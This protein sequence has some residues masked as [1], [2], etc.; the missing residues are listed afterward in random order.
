MHDKIKAGA[1]AVLR[2]CVL[3]P[4][5]AVTVVLI[6]VCKAL[7]MVTDDMGAYEL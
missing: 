5:C 2:W 7:M 3:M 1:K 6:G 4:L